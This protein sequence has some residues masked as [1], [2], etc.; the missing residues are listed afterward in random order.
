MG[1]ILDQL[2]FLGIAGVGLFGDGYLNITIG[3]VV[4]IIGYLYY[5]DHKYSVP[6]IQQDTIKG[7]L[8]L[9][10]IVGQISFGLFGDALGRHKIYGKELIIT[11]LGNFLLIMMPWKHFG[12]G[13]VV[14]WMFVFRFVTGLGIGGD[15]P[16]TSSIAA[17]ND[18]FGSRAKLV[19][20]VFSF[21]GLG[22]FTGALVF[23][24]LLAAFKSAINADPNHLQWVW[25]LQFG[26]GLIPLLATL[27]ARLTMKES[28]PYE[29]YVAKETGL[30]SKNKR[31]LGEQLQDFRD[32]FS[33]WKNART[34]FAV[35]AAWF[36]FDIAFY[37]IN[38]NQSIVL[39]R[40]GFGKGK[41]PF[42]TL[43]NI[44]VGN[45]IVDIAGYLPGFYLAIFLPDRIGRVR[46]QWILSAVVAVLYAIWAGV[47]DHTSTGGLITIFTL[48][49]LF[50][51]MG[52]NATTFLLPVEVFP[53][54]VRAT[55][56]GIAA[57]SG[58]AGAVLTAFAFGTITDRIGLKGVLGLFA[59][60]M[61][62]CAAVSLLIPETKGKSIAEIEAEAV[63]SNDR[64][65]VIESDNFSSEIGSD[66]IGIHEAKG[67]ATN[68]RS[69][70]EF[71]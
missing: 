40:I 26:L 38:L 46:Q 12:H 19:L 6:T 29:Q 20:T 28:K 69:Q 5:E 23:L 53:T 7:A 9:G 58:K 59:G 11:I 51:N 65:P 52:P 50:L 60:I 48:S 68:L 8:A 18:R 36:L 24:I 10:M 62:L 70:R 66:E 71:A 15:Y 13:D 64:T 16:M 63:Y 43:W 39:T 35:C 54:R 61:A 56:H 32:Y 27:Y 3:L 17:E 14:A 30:A 31:G 57:A 42:E 47:T 34:L 49:Q 41:T 2:E 25:R 33:H 21:I 37:G 67:A 22:G 45:L 44:A 55:A 4:P 1:R